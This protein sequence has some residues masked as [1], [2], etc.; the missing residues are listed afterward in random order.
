MSDLILYRALRPAWSHAPLSG[1]GAAVN[2]GRWNRKGRVA[3]YLAGDPQ[4]ALE[5]YW[6]GVE[7]RPATIVE[8][9][10]TGAS[11][12]SIDDPQLRTECDIPRNVMTLNWRDL[13][14]NWTMPQWPE[15]RPLPRTW[16]ISECILKQGF[17]GLSYPSRITGEPC[18]CIWHWGDGSACKIFANDTARDLP[19]NNSSWT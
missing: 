17:H 8:Y 19:A 2:G 4:T 16:E 14:K 9:E 5:E 1:D 18:Y 10:V 6:Q 11:I 15:R 7:R 12:A 3:L 13:S